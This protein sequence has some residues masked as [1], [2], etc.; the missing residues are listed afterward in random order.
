MAAD[1]HPNRSM[2]GDC[3]QDRLDDYWNGRADGYDAYQQ[4]PERLAA[5]RQAWGT[6]FSVVLPPAPARVLDV[7][8]GS[9]YV[10]MLL[11]DLGHHVTGIDHAEGMLSL[12]RRHAAA[13]RNPPRI[14]H[15]DATCPPG[16]PGSFDAITSRYL[17]WT[18]RD[19]VAALAAWWALLRPGGLLVIVDATWFPGGLVAI[20]TTP[21]F[22]DYYD[23]YAESQLPLAT[24]TSICDTVDL[25]TRAGFV[26][27][28]AVPLPDVLDL[29]LRHGVAP[30][31]QPR[32]QYRITGRR[33]MTS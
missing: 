7:G 20:A 14:R 11:A 22:T 26:D 16:E 1:A 15:G 3:L 12:A 13:H 23:E 18:L 8:T 17:M 31:H 19:P 4:R 30:G 10:A 33:P 6:A 27:V 9:G 24:S 21:E 2:A 25:V 5:D 29:D 32:M 28:C